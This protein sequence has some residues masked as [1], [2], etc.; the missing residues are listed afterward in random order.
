M[1][2]QIKIITQHETKIFGNAQRAMKYL[3]T[4]KAT[5]IYFNNES[6]CFLDLCELYQLELSEKRHNARQFA[7]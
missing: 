5:A 1:K 2:L 4:H 6:C 7:A 3:K